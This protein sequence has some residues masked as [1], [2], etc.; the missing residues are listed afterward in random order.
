MWRSGRYAPE[1]RGGRGNTVRI[2]GGPGACGH[3]AASRTRRP[4]PP[5]NR[6]WTWPY[7]SC[8][9]RRAAVPA[10]AIARRHRRIVA[11]HRECGRVGALATRPVSATGVSGHDVGDTRVAAG[12]KRVLSTRGGSEGIENQLGP[13]ARVRCRARGSSRGSA[14][15]AHDSPASSSRKRSVLTGAPAPG[16]RL[17]AC[18]HTPIPW[19]SPG[20]GHAG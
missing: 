9:R 4:C 18:S 10:A 1:G 11:V 13:L 14:C 2:V 5:D 6:F 19:R 20:V 8:V 16:W 17:G 7:G 15:A 12:A 3:A